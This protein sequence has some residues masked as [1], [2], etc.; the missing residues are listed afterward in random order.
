MLIIVTAL[1]TRNAGMHIEIGFKYPFYSHN[2]F[3]KNIIYTFD[4]PSGPS[5]SFIYPFDILTFPNDS[6]I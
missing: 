1:Y 4:I 2:D 3:L 5:N 6:F